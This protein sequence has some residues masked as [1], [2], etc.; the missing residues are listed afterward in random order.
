M[1]AKRWIAGIG[2]ALCVL[3]A[4]GTLILGNEQ[5]RQTVAYTDA[6]HVRY[7]L[8]AAGGA[9]RMEFIIDGDT[10]YRVDNGRPV[11]VGKAGKKVRLHPLTIVSKGEKTTVAGFDAF[12]AKVKLEGGTGDVLLSD[13]PKLVEA[14][15]V[16][17][18]ASAKLA[19][20]MPMGMGLGDE[21]EMDYVIDGKYAVVGF[22]EMM[23]L[24]SFSDAPIDASIFQRLK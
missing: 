11:K 17:S 15:K 5:M 12:K 10:I 1:K 9:M 22:T 21:G 3:S 6:E 24:V 23:K 16:F 19:S 20:G 7:I 8:E 14:F 4:D 2:M 18:T 13:D